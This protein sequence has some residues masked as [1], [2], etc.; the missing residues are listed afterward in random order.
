MRAKGLAFN[1]QSY[2]DMAAKSRTAGDEVAD[3]IDFDGARSPD[4]VR[5]RRDDW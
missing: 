2:Y 5:P 4:V 3:E 1:K